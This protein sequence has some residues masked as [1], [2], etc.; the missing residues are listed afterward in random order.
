MRSLMRFSPMA[1]AATLLLGTALALAAC[2]GSTTDPEPGGTGTTPAPA[3]APTPPPPPAARIDTIFRETFESGSLAAWEDGFVAAKHRV[4]TNATLAYSGSR[5]LDVT[6]PAGDDGGWLTRFF[7]PGYDSV[8]VSY[9]VR[10]PADWVGSTKLIA[11]YGSRLDNQWSAF[12]KAGVRPD[13]TDFMAAYLTN[14]PEGTP[15]ETRFYTYFPDMQRDSDG[16]WWGDHGIGRAT[17][18]PPL[19]MSL[20]AWH[21]IEFWVKLNTPGQSNGLQRFWMD[22]V[23]K[24]EWTG[25]RFRDTDQ[26]RLNSLQLSFSRIA[27]VSQYTQHMYVD[28]IL[29]LTGRPSP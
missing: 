26:I 21:H 25:L 2:A 16:N 17:Y 24:G 11:L 10:F 28:E 4:I 19:T 14:G 3:P 6:Y 8:Y 29:V 1:P 20:G 13:G 9:R 18:H 15:G 27:S 5:L 22:G 23:F 12:G 7:M